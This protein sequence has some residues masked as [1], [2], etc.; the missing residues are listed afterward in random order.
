MQPNE[1]V[2]RIGYEF[3]NWGHPDSRPL[4]ALGGMGG[5]YIHRHSDSPILV[6]KCGEGSVIQITVY[7]SPAPQGSKR[8][9]GIKGGHGVMVESSKAVKPWREAVKYAALVDARRVAGPVEVEMIFTLKKPASAPKRIRTW[10]D[11]KPD[12]SKLVRSTEDALTDAGVWED[13]ARVVKTA[14]EK[15][16]PGTHP[17]SLPVPGAT[18]RI[19]SV[20]E[21]AETLGSL[22]EVA[23]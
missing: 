2:V 3:D 23:R 21:R 7:G 18:I 19:W 17:L 15:C 8:F 6:S 13:D 16:F 9:L 11:K 10:P 14:S 22:L 4:G 5:L 12:L 20:S 1:R